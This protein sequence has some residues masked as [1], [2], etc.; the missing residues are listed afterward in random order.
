VF[1][2]LR[3]IFLQV[4]LIFKKNF[5][6]IFFLNR[7]VISQMDFSISKL[8]IHSFD[9]CQKASMILTGITIVCYEIY[10]KYKKEQIYRNI[11]LNERAIKQENKKIGELL[12][13]LVPNFVKESLIQGVQTLSEDQGDVTLLFCDICNFDKIIKQEN[14]R[15]IELLDNLYRTFDTYCLENDVQKIEVNKII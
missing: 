2:L 4:I 1:D 12:S 13:I 8:S 7:V 14:C 3:F 6:I 15:V 11:F 9:S 10:C 5:K